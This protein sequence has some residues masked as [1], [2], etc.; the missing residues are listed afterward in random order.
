MGT[1]AADERTHPHPRRAARRGLRSLAGEGRRRRDVHRVRHG[2]PRG[3]RRRQRQRRA[4][5]PPGPQGALDADAPGRSRHRP[6]GGRGHPDRRGPL[7]VRRRGVGRPVRDLAPRRRDQDPGRRRRR[8]DARG[9]RASSSSGRR[10]PPGHRPAARRC[11]TRRTRCATTS[12]PVEA[13]LAAADSPDVVATLA[14]HPLRDFVTASERLPLW[15]DRE[16]ALFSS[17]YEFF[18]RSEGARHGPEDG[19]DE[20]GHLPHGHGAAARRRGDGL[21][22]RLPAADPP[23]RDDEPQ[24]PE[25]HPDP[26]PGR[27]RLA[28]GDRRRRGRARRDP[29]R[30][31]HDRGLRRVRGPRQR[32]R[33]RGGARLRPAG[34]A[35]P[36]VGQGAPRVVHRARRRHRSPTPR[37]RRRST[38]TSTRSTSTATPT[39]STPRCCASLRH[40]MDHGVRIFRVD[41]PHTKP[42]AFWE[43][44]LAEVRRT[45][46]DVLFLAEAFTRPAMM[47]TLARVG[48]HQSYTYFT[49]RNEKWELEEYLTELSQQ[50]GALPAAQLLRQHAGHPARLPAVRRAG[51]VQDPG[52]PGRDPLAVLGRL[53]RLRAVRAR[54]ASGRA[55]RSTSTRRS[56]SSGRATGQAAEARGPHAGALPHP[57]QPDPA[58]RTRRCSGCATC[59]STA[60]TATR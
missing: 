2:V 1:F 6:L 28:V 31:R 54:R 56:T 60:P 26:R 8:A 51:G 10:G 48:F 13:R 53:L 24:G 55:A 17:W 37:T 14:A 35:R 9:G 45:D 42:V 50:T 49:W 40:W 27:P 7:D 19:G 5:R 41:N 30:P 23:D 33:A 4:A 59:A 15:V 32:A 44:L 39:A 12:R 57:A 16:R 11:S 36:P 38:R 43:W 18:P 34:H 47:Q 29:P 20:V 58:R 52:R 3:P 21:R 46:P 22:R 25:Q